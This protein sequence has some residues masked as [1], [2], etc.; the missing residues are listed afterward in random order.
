MD[1]LVLHWASLLRMIFAS[2]ACAHVRVHVQNVGDFPQTKLGSKINTHFLLNE[3]GNLH[4]L[5]HDFTENNILKKITNLWLL[6]WQLKYIPQRG[7]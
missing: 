4:F 3:H 5:S 6:Y 7:T 2:L 1:S